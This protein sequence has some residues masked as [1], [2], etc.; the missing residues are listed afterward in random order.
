MEEE[1]A[2]RDPAL[3]ATARAAEAHAA[4]GSLHRLVRPFAS[5]ALDAFAQLI[6]LT[7]SSPWRRACEQPTELA[8]Q[9]PCCDGHALALNA[10]SL[11]HVATKDPD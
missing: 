1:V 7:S 5:L 11:P 6:L 8:L 4:R 10:A 2:E 9:Q 3:K